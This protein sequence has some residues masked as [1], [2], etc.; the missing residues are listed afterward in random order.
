MIDINKKR[1]LLINPKMVSITSFSKGYTAE[2][3]DLLT[4]KIQFARNGTLDYLATLDILPKKVHIGGRNIFY[5]CQNNT[6]AK[7]DFTLNYYSL[8]ASSFEENQEIRNSLAKQK[9]HLEHLKNKIHTSVGHFNVLELPNG[10]R[11]NIKRGSVIAQSKEELIQKT[12]QE[13]W[14]LLKENESS[15]SIPTELDVHYI[16]F[17]QTPEGFE[18]QYSYT[19]QQAKR[20]SKVSPT[21]PSITKKADDERYELY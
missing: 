2:T 3:N 8:Y 17:F 15:T 7:I 19:L 20:I 13:L 14:N 16:N 5:D 21:T 11:V 1:I 4:K 18:A 12:K 9:H 6:A 10:H